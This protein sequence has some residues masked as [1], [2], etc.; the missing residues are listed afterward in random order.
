[1]T[2]FTK[3]AVPLFLTI[4]GAVL[5]DKEESLKVVFKKRILKIIK[6]LIVLSIIYYFDGLRCGIYDFSIKDFLRRILAQEIFTPLWFLYEYLFFLS[7]LPFLRI[8][9]KKIEKEHYY[10]MAIVTVIFIEIVPMIQY[11]VFKSINTNVEILRK[12]SMAVVYPC[13]GY[14]LQNK[15]KISK[16][17]TIYMLWIVN[18]VTIII[19]C[20]L[21]YYKGKITGVFSEGESQTFLW[22]FVLVNC[23]C[24]YST[25]KYIIEHIK[26]PQMIQKL[27]FSIG[28]CTFGIYLFHALIKQSSVSIKI[29]NIILNTGLNHM[30][31]TLV[32]CFGVMLVTYIL[33]LIIKRIPILN[34]IIEI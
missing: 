33:V 21:T 29:L 18:V 17:K 4:S 8:L 15:I 32:W 14:F 13:I 10:Y 5:L 1:M 7:I 19:T 20:L 12:C 30:L 22:M 27:I 23:V 11:F 31:S 16:P 24:I 9:V 2:V 6:I 3:F 26:I 34:K 25:I 28:S